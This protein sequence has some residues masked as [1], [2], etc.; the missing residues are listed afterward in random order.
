MIELDL[1]GLDIP[2]KREPL[3][4]KMEMMLKEDEV[5]SI[6]I[7]GSA[8]RG[9]A[10]DS[11]D[12]DTIIVL[13]DKNRERIAEIKEKLDS[14][15]IDLKD[16]GIN[17]NAVENIGGLF[18][19][20]FVTDKES[21]QKGDVSEIFGFP[22]FAKL[23]MPW[24]TLLHRLSKD[25]KTVYGDKISFEG[26]DRFDPSNYWVRELLKGFMNHFG[27]SLLALFYLPFSNRALKY[28]MEGYKISIYNCSY[29]IDQQSITLEESIES[30]PDFLGVQTIF[31]DFRSEEPV[32]RLK[33][34]VL[35]PVAILLNY[36]WTFS[37]IARGNHQ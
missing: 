21:Y 33:F 7:Y 17:E 20:C 12:I 24:R 37:Q 9:E 1:Q 2:E 36:I 34:A 30:I 5:A 23:L 22:F 13:K 14:V 10:T 8:T 25:S 19:S 29:L 31:E 3:L 16:A 6:V 28:S 26:Y 4:R 15:E 35:V 32:P 18:T 11:S 27:L